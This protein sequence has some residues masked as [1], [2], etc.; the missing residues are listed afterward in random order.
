MAEPSTTEQS[1]QADVDALIRSVQGWPAMQRLKLAQAILKTLEP[2]VEPR[3]QRK[4]TA[5]EA[6]GLLA[7]EQL[8][9]NDAEVDALIA[10]Y[11]SE[12]YG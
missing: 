12:K 5:A 11:L 4:F 9:P 8:A 10:E 1:S 7:G 3:Q 6:T 2:A